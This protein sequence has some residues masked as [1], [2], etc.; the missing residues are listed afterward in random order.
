MCLFVHDSPGAAGA[1]AGAAAAAAASLPSAASTVA[2]AVV[3]RCCYRLLLVVVVVVLLLLLLLVLLVLLAAMPL[4]PAVKSC[5]G[6]VAQGHPRPQTAGWAGCL[7]ACVSLALCR[8]CIRR[9][10]GGM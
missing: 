10:E 7:A 9:V 4:G 1:G 5:D 6:G 2:I 3:C 8:V